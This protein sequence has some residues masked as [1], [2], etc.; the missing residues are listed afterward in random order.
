MDLKGTYKGFERKNFIF[1]WHDPEEQRFYHSNGNYESGCT[2][3]PAKDIEKKHAIV[4]GSGIAGLAAA[5]YLVRDA[6]MPGE[7]TTVYETRSVSGGSCDGMFIPGKGYVISGGREMDDHFECMWDL[8]KD[9]PSCDDKNVSILDAYKRLNE[10]DPNYSNC[11]V[12]HKR[13]QDAGFNNKFNMSNKAQMEVLKVMLMKDDDLYGKP[14]DDFFTDETF[15]SNFWYY[16]K[17]MFAFKNEHSALEVKLY[18][19]RFIHHLEGFTDLSSLRFCKYNNYD[20]IILPMEN[21]LKERGV[22]FVYHAMVTNVLFDIQGGTKTAKTVE[23]TIEG[24]EEKVE[25]NENT[26]V[27]FTNGSNTA[28][29]KLGDHHTVP[30]F[31]TSIYGSWKTWQNIA[32]QDPSFGNP[33]ELLADPELTQWESAT[34]TTNDNEILKYITNVTGRDPRDGKVVTGGIVTVKD[35][36][37][38]MSWTINRQKHFLDQNSEENTIVWIYALYDGNKGNYVKKGMRECTGEEIAKEWLYHIGCPDDRIDD[39]AA[40]GCNCVPCMMPRV[41]TYFVSRNKGTYPDV[42]PKGVTN[43]AFLGNH[44]HVERDCSFTT[45]KSIRSAMMAVYGLAGVNRAIPEVYNSIY[46]IRWVLKAFVDM[47]DGEPLNTAQMFEV[48]SFLEKPMAK[49]QELLLNKVILP[50]VDKTDLGVLLRRLKVF[51][52]S[53][54]KTK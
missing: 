44:A 8:F 6:R 50:A 33:D 30:E 32:K 37:W 40:N 26:F 21:W 41:T 36:G 19:Q 38:V 5:C 24:K 29:L 16:F 22:K 27:F 48:P 12:S 3:L 25:I 46:D 28:N 11:R 18:L 34:L 39:L 43:F 23:V 1:N 14:I 31:D 15:N 13:G 42:L 53:G 9:I 20:S 51:D 35:S 47:R 4:I 10:A 7:N 17:T 2:T 52:F 49:G 54:V 45:E